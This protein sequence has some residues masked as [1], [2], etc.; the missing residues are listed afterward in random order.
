MTKLQALFVLYWRHESLGDCSWRTLASLYYD[1]YGNILGKTPV[2]IGNQL[3]GINLELT[4]IKV[5]FDFD[6]ELN[7]AMDYSLYNCDL[8]YINA[9]LKRHLK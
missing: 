5:L 3:D 8:T 4:A 1:R 9:N 6:K 2:M 7:T